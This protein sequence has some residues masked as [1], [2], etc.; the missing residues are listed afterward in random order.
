MQARSRSGQ[1]KQTLNMRSLWPERAQCCC[2]GKVHGVY[3]SSVRS[4]PLQQALVI[5][6]LFLPTS[7]I[8][9]TSR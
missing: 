5:V 7:G 1:S 6:Q 9:P 3:H 4:G 8:A 2:A